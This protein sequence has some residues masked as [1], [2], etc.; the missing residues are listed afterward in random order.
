[1]PLCPH[2]GRP[3][4]D[5][6][7]IRRHVAHSPKCQQAQLAS[8]KAIRR[9]LQ[10]DIP[11]VGRDEEVDEEARP[12]ER[13]MTVEDAPNDED[14]PMNDAPDVDMDAYAQ[15]MFD[16]QVNPPVQPQRERPDPSKIYDFDPRRTSGLKHPRKAGAPVSDKKA[17]TFFEKLAK[18]YPL[19][20]GGNF[21]PFKSEIEWKFAQWTAK[22][23]GMGDANELL[24]LEF[25][26]DYALFSSITTSNHSYRSKIVT[27]R[28]TMPASSSRR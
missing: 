22:T 17:P 1:M 9:R 4:R 24:N 12:R 7:A 27:H 23:L 13:S 10:R 19:D 25:V 15:E 28:S 3:Q 5:S 18:K 11:P 20:D 16:E 21:G 14:F 8:W 6:E 2:C 26:S